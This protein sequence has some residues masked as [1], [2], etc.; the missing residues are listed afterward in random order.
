MTRH[1][2]IL[3]FLQSA[4]ILTAQPDM[5]EKERN[6]I[7][8]LHIRTR[9]QWD[10]RYSGEKLSSK[11]FRSARLTYDEEGRVVETVNYKSDTTV[12]NLT[13]Y[14]YN[15]LGLRTGMMK[16]QG[17]HK[18]ILFSSRTRYDGKGNKLT[19]DGFNGV[20]NFRNLYRYDNAGRLSQILYYQGKRLDESRTFS[21]HDQTTEVKVSDGNGNLQY[22]LVS[23]KDGADRVLEESKFDPNKE[24]LEHTVNRYNLKGDLASTE[25]QTAD[26]R[27]NKAL[28]TYDASNNVSEIYAEETENPKYLKQSYTYTNNGLVAAEYWRNNPSADQSYHK[29]TYDKAGR[30]I[31]TDCFFASY[32]FRVLNRFIY[33]YYQPGTQGTH[34]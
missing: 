30:L 26:K 10:Y 31:S 12:M 2:L 28:Y 19:E 18:V 20:D 4:A 9:E 1:L 25:K 23:V 6:L 24:L 15:E 32:K 34:D 3:L 21:Y 27:W 16:Y 8:S 22:T 17:D 14:T 33:H 29:N 7:K 11:G 13:D 5:S